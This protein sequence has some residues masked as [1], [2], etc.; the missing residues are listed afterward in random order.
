ML[1][2]SLTEDSQIGADLRGCVDEKDQADFDRP[3]ALLTILYR[4]TDRLCRAGAPV[5]NLP[6]VLSAA[7]ELA[8]IHWD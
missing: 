3:Y 6:R 5:K 7:C 2:L 1:V 8:I 4:A